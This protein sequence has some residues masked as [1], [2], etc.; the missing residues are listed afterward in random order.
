MLSGER[1]KE[2]ELYL[3]FFL[4]LAVIECL[5][6]QVAAEYRLAQLVVIIALLFKVKSGFL[7]NRWNLVV[8]TLTLLPKHFMVISFPSGVA[9]VI[10]V[11]SLLTPILLIVLT[12]Q[13]QIY[14]SKGSFYSPFIR[15]LNLSKNRV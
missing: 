8:L 10:T 2:L 4:F 9:N 3:V 5:Y 15:F 6:P 12:F 7:E 11:S 1:A 14:L 13:I